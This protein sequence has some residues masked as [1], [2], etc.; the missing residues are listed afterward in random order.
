[1]K[2]SYILLCILFTF[3]LQ[4]QSDSFT[5]N[6]NTNTETNIKLYPNPATGGI[7][8]IT[9]TQN[10]PKQVY[11]FD[12]FGKIVLTDTIRT[13]LLDISELSPGIYMV[14]IIENNIATNRKLVV[15]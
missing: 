15:R 6:R 5:G 3:A 14:Q 2:K 11:V 12:V 1:M 4:A 9:S 10:T 8:H 13:T 7:V